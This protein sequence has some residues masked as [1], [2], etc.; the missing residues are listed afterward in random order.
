[1]STLLW[2]GKAPGDGSACDEVYDRRMIVAL[3]QQG[4]DVTVAHPLRVAKTQEIANLACG[5]P[6]YRAQ[7]MSRA[8]LQ[9]LA[10]AG[11][12]WRSARGSR[13]TCWPG[14]CR[15]RPCRSSTT[16]PVSL[17]SMFP[18]HR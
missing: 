4:I 13:S 17:P 2:I 15:S 10:D 5:F 16:L 18:A 1:M 11:M 6:H 3:L 9:L 14:T 12:R 7:Y 8:N